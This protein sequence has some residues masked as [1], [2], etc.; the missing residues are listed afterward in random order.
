MLGVSRTPVREALARLQ[1]RGLVEAT[2]LGLMAAQL[3]HQQTLELYALRAVLEGAAARFATQHASESEILALRQPCAA[4]AEA[5]GSAE[6]LARL[7]RQFHLGI[8]EAAHNRYLK[9][10]LEDLHITLALLPSTTFTVAGR[11]EAVIVEHA[12]ILEAI[13]RRDA[14][15]AEAAARDHIRNAQVPRLQVLFREMPG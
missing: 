2:P 1:E 11:P 15:A 4:F 14:D 5:L 8:I 6:R 3:G 10:A 7:N 9:R 13:A 12:A